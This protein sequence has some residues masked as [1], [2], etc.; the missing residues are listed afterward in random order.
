MLSIIVTPLVLLERLVPEKDQLMVG[1]SYPDTV[2]ENEMSLY[3]VTVLSTGLV[4]N[5]VPTVKGE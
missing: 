1:L 5:L 2:Q 4:D 3:S